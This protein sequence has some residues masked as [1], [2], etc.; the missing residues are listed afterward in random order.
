MKALFSEIQLKNLKIKNRVVMPPMVIFKHVTADGLITKEHIAHY[1][2]RAK[3]GVG[4]IIVE[5]ACVNN[6]GRLAPRQLGLW[7]DA[8][9]E[10]LREIPKAC[11]K[12][13]AKVLIQ[14]HHAGAKTPLSVCSDSVCPSSFETLL[15]P[16][17]PSVQARALTLSEI[18]NLQNDFVDAAIRAKEAGFDGIELHGAHGY[19]INQFFSPLINK[20]TDSYGGSLVNRGRFAVEIITEIKQVVG[21]DFVIGCRMGCNEPDLQTSIALAKLLENAGVQ[22]LHISFGSGPSLNFSSQSLLAAC[23][24]LDYSWVV[25][26]GTEMKKHLMVP[27]IVVFGIRN[28]EEADALIKN[29]LADFTAIGKGLLAD[30]SWAEK[31]QKGEV[32]AFCRSCK[33]CLWSQSEDLCPARRAVNS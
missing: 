7:S 2:E 20:R 5:A 13:G 17:T 16:D 4:L 10:G 11:H 9:I 19:L 26:G 31:A 30:P 12:H 29:N 1:E 24:G 28:P 6:N 8:F 3:A 25:H 15:S 27:V 22:L 18:H 23:P 32:I 21:N 14:L 33:K